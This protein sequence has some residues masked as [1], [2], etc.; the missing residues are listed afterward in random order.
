MI[1]ENARLRHELHQAAEQVKARDAAYLQ[2]SAK[3]AELSN[4]N[5]AI[6]RECA[7]IQRKNEDAARLIEDL[8]AVK[9]E[10]DRLKASL[11]EERK[12]AEEIDA[13]NVIAL[14]KIVYF[15]A[16][17]KTLADELDS[18]RTEGTSHEQT[19]NGSELETA[20]RVKLEEL[21]AVHAKEIESWTN[22]VA[23]GKK[24]EKRLNQDKEQAEDDM[25]YFKMQ[26]GEEA[27]IARDAQRELGEVEKK[28]KE[29]QRQLNFGVKQVQLFHEGVQQRLNEELDRARVGLAL[30]NQESTR[31]MAIR[32]KAARWD[33]HQ[34]KEKSKEAKAAKARAERDSEEA[35]LAM[36]AREIADAQVI[37]RS[38]T[39]ES[40]E[41]FFS[42]SILLPQ[43]K[44]VDV[45]IPDITI[46]SNVALDLVMEQI[47]SGE[48]SD[49]EDD[50]LVFEC[51]WEEPTQCDSIL[52]S[53]D[54]SFYCLP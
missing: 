50:P 52:P 18:A 2:A 33:E 40:S 29:L 22:K 24:R 1:A 8:T 12:R 26:R 45:A 42:T 54:V 41:S 3:N 32:T 39:T 31:T 23:D 9:D 47:G 34:A 25:N 11:K 46:A 53:R 28:V 27:E 10:I 49:D 20:M 19:Q 43:A 35:Y 17:N 30:A 15:E 5:Q 36:R 44:A 37:A 13:L 4:A 7:R 38:I 16:Q 14:G 48:E 51:K 21:E 6:A